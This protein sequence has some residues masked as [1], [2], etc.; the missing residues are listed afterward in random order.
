MMAVA[1]NDPRDLQELHA[2]VCR[3]YA[4]FRKAGGRADSPYL[5]FFLDTMA[6]LERCKAAGQKVSP[7]TVVL[8]DDG[9]RGVIDLMQVF[10]EMGFVQ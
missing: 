8:R 1:T 4:Q 2:S 10:K 5:L 7:T 6:A 3:K 9:T